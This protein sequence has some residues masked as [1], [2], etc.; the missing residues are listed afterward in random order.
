MEM[1][2]RSGKKQVKLPTLLK[3]VWFWP[4]DIEN[5][6]I[7][8]R[9]KKMKV[10]HFYNK[11]DFLFFFH[12]KWSHRKKNLPDLLLLRSLLFMMG[13]HNKLFPFFEAA[14]EAIAFQLLRLSTPRRLQQYFSLFFTVFSEKNREKE[15]RRHPQ[16]FMW[17]LKTVHLGQTSLFLLQK[18]H[19][20]DLEVHTVWKSKNFSTAYVLRKIVL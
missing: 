14:V 20:Y 7:R 13:Y 6:S 15:V 17:H 12:E 2:F 3:T 8:Y 4:T 18:P 9:R 11:K 16:F 10:Y 1:L 5:Q 19:F